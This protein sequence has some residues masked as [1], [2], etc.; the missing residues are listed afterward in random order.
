MTFDDFIILAR[1][2]FRDP[3]L[4]FAQLRRLDLPVSARWMAL[5]LLAALSSIMAALAMR[6]F[7]ALSDGGL[8]LPE[9]SPMSRAG[10][11]LAGMALTAWLVAVIG[12]AFGGRGDF[13][14]ALLVVAWL[15]FLML[16]AQIVQ[17]GVMLVFPLLGSMLGIAALLAILWASVQMIK[18]LHGFSNAALVFMGLLGAGLVVLLF[19]SVMAGALGLMPELPAEV[20]P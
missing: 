16:A 5:L 11:Q 19:L 8:G 14:D 15:E 6:V 10:L 17:L 12:G 1:N 18:A 4:A 20:Q 13:S 7:P 9:L 2:T 3:P